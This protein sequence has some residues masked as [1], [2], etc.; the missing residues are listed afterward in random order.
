LSGFPDPRA[1]GTFPIRGTRYAGLAAFAFAGTDGQLP[2][3]QV[4]A[5]GACRHYEVNWYVRAS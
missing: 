3:D 1:D 2:S 4:R 5:D